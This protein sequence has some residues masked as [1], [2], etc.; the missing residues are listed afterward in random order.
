MDRVK[1]ERCHTALSHSY[2][3]EKLLGMNDTSQQ[4]KCSLTKYSPGI[5]YSLFLTVMVLTYWHS[6]FAYA[7][8]AGHL[9]FAVIT[10]IWMFLCCF[11]EAKSLKEADFLLFFCVICLVYW[12]K[13]F[14]FELDCQQTNFICKKICLLYQYFCFLMYSTYWINMSAI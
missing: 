12:F 2:R 14:L 3:I 8:Y 6:C 10:L 11:G 7:V 9:N 4:K 1:K 13:G 5:T